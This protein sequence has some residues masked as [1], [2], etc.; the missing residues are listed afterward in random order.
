M[1]TQNGLLRSKCQILNAITHYSRI[2]FLRTS[3]HSQYVFIHRSYTVYMVGVFLSFTWCDWW[4]G[5]WEEWRNPPPGRSDG[6]PAG[7]GWC[8][9]TCFRWLGW[10]P[11]VWISHNRNMSDHAQ[12]HT[13]EGDL[14]QNSP[15]LWGTQCILSVINQS[16]ALWGTRLFQLCD[17]EPHWDPLLCWLNFASLGNA[18]KM[19]TKIIKTHS[20]QG[21]LVYLKNQMRE[22][23]RQ[24][25]PVL[26]LKRHQVVIST[27]WWI[28]SDLTYLEGWKVFLEISQLRIHTWSWDLS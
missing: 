19:S 7:C 15:C 3:N 8:G 1:N 12:E 13:Q 28:W 16:Y 10:S 22:V 9:G 5:L 21:R 11:D 17:M 23:V 18:S 24:N 27:Q 4:W 2:S 25:V 6:Q 20:Q 14:C 26:L